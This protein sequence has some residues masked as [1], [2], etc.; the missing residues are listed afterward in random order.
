MKPTVFDLKRL[1]NRI[2]AEFAA[3]DNFTSPY[4]ESLQ[5]EYETMKRELEEK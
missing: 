4:I 2:T 3:N 5:A 1:A